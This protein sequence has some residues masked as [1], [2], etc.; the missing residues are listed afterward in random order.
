VDKPFLFFA[1]KLSSQLPWW[2]RSKLWYALL[3]RVAHILDSTPITTCDLG[4]SM[5]HHGYD[6]ICGAL[7]GLIYLVVGSASSIWLGTSFL[8][9]EISALSGRRL[10]PLGQGGFNNW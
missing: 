3:R 7:V 6:I 10:P 2:S 9:S 8:P 1:G 4:A 5:P